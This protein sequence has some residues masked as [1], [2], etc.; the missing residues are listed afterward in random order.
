MFRYTDM[1]EVELIIS[2]NG[3]KDN[4]QEYL[5]SLTEKYEFLGMQNH[6][7]IAWND[8]PLGYSRAC[9]AGIE[10]ATTD[11]IVLLNNDVIFLDQTRS[12]WLKLLENQ[13]KINA[14]CGISCV[15]KGHSDCAGQDFA[16]FFVV[17]I[18]RKV[19]DKIGMLNTEYGVGGGEDTEFSIETERAGFEVCPAVEM[20]WDHQ[21]Q[22]YTGSFPVYHKGEG[23]VHD[24]K[25][26]PNWND[27][28]LTNSL[29]LAK[30]YNPSWYQ[31]KLSNYCERAVIFKGDQVPTREVTKYQWAAENL[32][33][34][35]VFELGCTSGFGIQF[36]PKHIEYTGVDYD[37]HV[38]DAARDQDWGYNAKFIHADINEYELD[39]YDTIIA[40]EVI[41]HLENG[42]EIVEKFKKHCKRLLITVPVLKPVGKW[43]PHHKLHNLDETNF[44]GF[45]FKYISPSGELLDNPQNRGDTENINLML[46][47]WDSE[48]TVD[49]SFL[50]DQH[51]EVY[52]EVIT[53]NS[54]RITPSSI[55]D[56][57]VIDIGANIGT[58]S[59]LAAS[60]GAKKVISVEPMGKTYAA[61]CKNIKLSNF[62]NI[63]PLKNAV[64][65]TRG[66]FIDISIFEN[67]GHTS[68]YLHSNNT[69]TVYT[70][71]LSELLNHCEGDDIFLK[72]DCEGAE[73]DII[74]NASAEDMKRIRKVAMEVHVE[75]HP[76]HKGFDVIG[77]KMKLHGFK[78]VY[79][80][81]AYTWD[82]NE[83]GERFNVRTM[84][85][86]VEFWER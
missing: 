51:E 6:F 15:I 48:E 23:T 8:L 26:V 63:V 65:S 86:R 40:F 80:Q 14:K 68:A 59:L 82:Q 32:C 83:H 18:H 41:A 77:Q 49:L 5:D 62:K 21:Q 60:M 66:E 43:G 24:P 10:K 30:K 54:Y 9:N 81:Q 73:Y 71:T 70:T 79:C 37:R 55:K 25:L 17:M 31:W 2:A 76:I 46:C 13:F 38:I 85:L 12:H 61:L 84:P 53:D 47:M 39:Q 45:K 19:F 3:C 57:Y 34:T 74:L 56:R 44:P 36:L 58:F 67:I 1:S 7:K 4:T 16:V 28:F 35:K 64:S 72:I 33:G 78:M 20:G 42:L 22:F 52:K 69:E 27:I 11:L 50:K 75:M 29:K